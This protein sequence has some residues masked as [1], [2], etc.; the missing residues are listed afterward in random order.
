[1]AGPGR[2][3]KAR[4]APPPPMDD[5]PPFSW[6]DYAPEDAVTFVVFWVLAAVVFAQFFTRYALNAPLAWTEE[7]ARYLLI[8]VTFLGG[9]IGVRRNSHIAVEFFYRWLP[10]RVARVLATLVD[11]IQVAF[12]GYLL[13]ISIKIVPLMHTQRMIVIP[14]PMSWVYGVVTVG[15]AI[16]TVRSLI[17]TW[18]QWHAG[19]ALARAAP[20]QSTD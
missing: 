2:E 5:E 3:G 13:Y 8:S 17:M 9:A 18:R 1:M 7:I 15:L 6:R 16:M 12:F 11:V 14:I 19:H 10:D 4:R 20:P